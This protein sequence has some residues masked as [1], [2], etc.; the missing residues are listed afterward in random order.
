MRSMRSCDFCSR[1]ASQRVGGGGSELKSLGSHIVQH[2]WNREHP[3]R[4]CQTRREHTPRELPLSVVVGMLWCRALQIY[5]E[6]SLHEKKMKCFRECF[7]RVVAL[8][9]RVRLSRSE[10]GVFFSPDC[11]SVSQ[12]NLFCWD[13]QIL[14]ELD[15][16]LSV[17]KIQYCRRGHFGSDLC[18]ELR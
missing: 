1:W 9:A 14:D 12:P 13:S 18:T 4:A 7:L 6:G 2:F 16:L 5:P 11:F 10:G 8:P 15:C 3:E 17:H